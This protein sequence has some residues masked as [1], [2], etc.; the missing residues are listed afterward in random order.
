[1]QIHFYT[2]VGVYFYRQKSNIDLYHLCSM[3]AYLTQMDF[4]STVFTFFDRQI[5]PG[6][7]PH[8]VGMQ[9]RVINSIHINQ[10]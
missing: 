8:S 6:D 9:K 1:M 2:P 10:V 4:T 3:M 5:N 7:T